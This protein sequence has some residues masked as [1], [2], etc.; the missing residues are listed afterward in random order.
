MTAHD[1]G[2]GAKILVDRGHEPPTDHFGITR[3]RDFNEELQSRNSEL[4]QS[5]AD[6]SNLLASV[7]MP[8]VM[9]DW[10]LRIRRI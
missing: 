9:L 5:N 6:L 10:D 3:I 2:F 8:I 4:S 1:L 7:Q